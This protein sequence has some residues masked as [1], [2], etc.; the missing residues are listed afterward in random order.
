MTFASI[1]F[2]SAVIFV[3]VLA[4]L[5][6]VRLFLR[7]GARKRAEAESKKPEPKKILTFQEVIL[8]AGVIGLFFNILGLQM[9]RESLAENVESYEVRNRPYVFVSKVE[10]QFN[11]D[12][13]AVFCTTDITNTGSVP[14]F[15]FKY[16]GTIKIGAKSFNLRTIKAEKYGAIYPD[17][18]FHTRF[19]FPVAHGRPVN[20]EL[21]L[22]YEDYRP[23]HYT[24]TVNYEY[25]PEWTT[26]RMTRCD[27]EVRTE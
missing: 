14:G 17:Q 24:F 18:V 22:S 4:A 20:V 27:E 23:Y 26:L 5:V 2:W 9:N 12:M 19:G 15:N 6:A 16:T 21:K 8:T 11:E 1:V 13:T 7:G 3:C 10:R 25:N